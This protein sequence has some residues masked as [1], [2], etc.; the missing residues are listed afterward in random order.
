[1]QTLIL[2]LKMSLE[3]EICAAGRSPLSKHTHTT[4]WSGQNVSW[5]KILKLKLNAKK[6]CFGD[7]E[8]TKYTEYEGIYEI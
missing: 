5:S 4:I 8:F 6:F 2:I 3:Y 1:M 7:G